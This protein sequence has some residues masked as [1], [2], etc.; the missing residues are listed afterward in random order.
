MYH[1]HVRGAR[2]PQNLPVFYITLYSKLLIEDFTQ[3]LGSLLEQYSIE[4]G[5]EIRVQACYDGNELVNHYH[6]ENLISYKSMQEI[7]EEL[8]GQGFVR[9]HTSAGEF[10][11]IIMVIF[12]ALAL[13]FC[14]R[15]PLKKCGIL[16]MF[17]MVIL[18]MAE[19]MATASSSL[20]E[21][22]LTL[23]IDDTVLANWTVYT[24]TLL[25]E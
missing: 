15:Q 25:S 20:M 11:P 4:S 2:V 10:K 23:I 3:Q 16:D 7:E 5:E 21:P 18:L 6:T 14:Y 1:N 13:S 24:T 9:C 12:L 22:F 19:S 17:S 8:K